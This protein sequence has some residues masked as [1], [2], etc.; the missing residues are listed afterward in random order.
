LPIAI[1]HS[2][3]DEPRVHPRSAA[4]SHVADSLPRLDGIS[5]LVV[6]DER[7]SLQLVARLFEGRGAAVTTAASASEA[8][9][10]ATA[11]PF[12][13][14]VSDIGMPGRD[15]Y[16]LIKDCRTR[17]LTTPAVALTAYARSEDRTKALS[18][19][20]QSHVAK[21]V[22]VA[23]LLAAVAALLPRRA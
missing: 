12:D 2:T 20:Y 8:L 1:V 17:G 13:V 9:A 3:P 19:G 4:T 6:D 15:G 23:E 10:L 21:P 5:I 7:D 16:E 14:L 22:E 11:R 18:S